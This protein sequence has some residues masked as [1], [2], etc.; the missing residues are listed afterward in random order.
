MEPHSPFNAAPSCSC[1]GV[2]L[3]SRVVQVG[4]GLL[5][6]GTGPLVAFMI[7]APR[8]NPIGPGLLA[9]FTFWPSVALIV[10]GS[11]L[12]LTRARRQ[13]ADRRADSDR[14]KMA[15]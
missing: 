11:V 12:A 13:P 10:I 3:R 5:I 9:F 2:I 4:A 1:A 6:L 7:L 15:A 14:P 8:S